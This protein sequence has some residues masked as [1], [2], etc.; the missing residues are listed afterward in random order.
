MCLYNYLLPAVYCF[1]VNSV[2]FAVD[3]LVETIAREI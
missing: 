3:L 1:H 2:D